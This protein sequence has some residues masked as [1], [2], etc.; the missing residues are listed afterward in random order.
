MNQVSRLLSYGRRYWARLLGST[1]LM[2]WPAPPTAR[3]CC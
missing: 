2:A 1:V 3:C